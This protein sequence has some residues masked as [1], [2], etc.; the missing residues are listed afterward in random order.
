MKRISWVPC[1]S[2]WCYAPEKDLK[3]HGDEAFRTRR[4]KIDE[5]NKWNWSCDDA[6][7]RPQEKGGKRR[8][9]ILTC[10][11]TD[12]SK[13]SHRE[14]LLLVTHSHV[15]CQL[16]GKRFPFCFTLG[17]LVNGVQGVVGVNG[18]PGIL[19]VLGSWECIG[20]S[21]VRSEN[22]K[23]VYDQLS[24]F[25]ILSDQDEQLLETFSKQSPWQYLPKIRLLSIELTTTY[26]QY[27]SQRKVL[28]LVML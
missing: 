7:H 13:S 25:T 4:L 27:R 19:G 1:L 5:C 3:A 20:V 11:N 8:K 28:L 24:P 17:L 16:V 14:I 26:I 12:S 10:S 2:P 9:D 15:P 21:S 22:N 23:S 6:Y 18:V